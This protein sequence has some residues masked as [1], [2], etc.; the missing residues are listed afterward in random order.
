MEVLPAVKAEELLVV[1]PHRLR[2]QWRHHHLLR[3]QD[4]LR[5]QFEE[6]V[7]HLKLQ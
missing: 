2:R 1:C 3:K 4:Q 5:P 6:V 7:E